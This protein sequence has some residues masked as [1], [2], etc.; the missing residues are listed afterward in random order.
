M[1][2]RATC[3]SCDR[4]TFKGCGAHVEQVL[5]DVAPADRC[6]CADLPRAPRAK[7]SWF[8]SKAAADT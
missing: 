2:R 3:P 8:R 6:R 7:R 4:P 1:C 5:A